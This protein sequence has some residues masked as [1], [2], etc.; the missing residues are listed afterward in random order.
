MHCTFSRVFPLRQSKF[1]HA[2][3]LCTRRTC[4]CQ[5]HL[6]H[7]LPPQST[8]DSQG[9]REKQGGGKG[10]RG[11]GEAIA[12][13][14]IASIYLYVNV[15]IHMY[16]SLYTSTNASLLPRRAG[17]EGFWAVGPNY[18]ATVLWGYKCRGTWKSGGGGETGGTGGDG[19]F[20]STY[21]SSVA[22]A[23]DE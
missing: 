1:A 16:T 8:S 13:E 12:G 14:A 10:S 9:A 3:F 11:E 17:C 4:G 2:A 7:V 18:R 19:G 20:C 23:K 15:F 5:H 22:A 21:M 6:I